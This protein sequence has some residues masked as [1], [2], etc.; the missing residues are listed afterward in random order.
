MSRILVEIV[1]PGS[2]SNNNDDGRYVCGF[3]FGGEYG[4]QQ[5]ILETSILG[6]AW[7]ILTLCLALW[8]VAKHLR[9]LQRTSTGWTIGGC[10]T[11]LIG[12]HVRY[13]IA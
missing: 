7:E 12:T 2:N 9:E 8:I 3:S 1:V 4:S 13:F 6:I 5:P 11:V 10:F